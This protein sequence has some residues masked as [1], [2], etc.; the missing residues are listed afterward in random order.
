LLIIFGCRIS[1][2]EA[3]L[4]MSLK[5]VNCYFPFILLIYIGSAAAGKTPTPPSSPPAVSTGNGTKK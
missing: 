1:L 3:L 2:Q 5:V 4:P